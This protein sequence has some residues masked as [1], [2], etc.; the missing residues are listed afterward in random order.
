MKTLVLGL[1]NELLSDDGVGLLAIRQ[2]REEYTGQ[3]ELVES[4]LHG[5]ALIDL[6]IGFDRT[7]IIDA[8][9]TG[10]HQPGEIIQLSP[11]DLDHVIA[12]SPHYSGM[13]EMLALAKELDLEFPKEIVIFAIEVIDPHTIGG[14]LTPLINEKL[15]NLVAMAKDQLAKWE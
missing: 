11:A 14:G 12:P 9:Q 3:A 1:G 7:I 15:P 4:S 8:I 10:K 13:P 5:L 2:L 6:F